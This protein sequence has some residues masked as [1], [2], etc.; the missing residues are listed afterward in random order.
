[1]VTT[2]GITLSLQVLLLLY[3]RTRT[4]TLIR[5]STG[6]RACGGS[7]SRRHR[8]TEFARMGGR[9]RESRFVRHPHGVLVS[10]NTHNDEIMH[11]QTRIRVDAYIYV[12]VVVGN[13]VEMY[14]WRCC[15]GM[16]RS[17]TNTRGGLRVDP[18]PSSRSIALFIR[19]G[20]GRRRWRGGR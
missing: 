16:I 20:R 9:R 19:R 1:M 14:R 8:L 11:L 17:S 4:P 12:S 15:C 7:S 10:Q 6:S 5:R 3:P 18:R 13:F 2:K